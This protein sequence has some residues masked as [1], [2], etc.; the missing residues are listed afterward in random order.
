LA[1]A[2]KAS[3]SHQ[4]PDSL[5]GPPKGPQKKRKERMKEGKK[6][7]EPEFVFTIR[8]LRKLRKQ[9]SN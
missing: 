4:F 1:L 8:K 5:L 6:E 2:S 3:T 9:E 7:R